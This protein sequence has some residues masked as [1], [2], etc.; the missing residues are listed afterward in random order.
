MSTQAQPTRTHRERRLSFG[1]ERFSALYL[2]AACIIT[3]GIWTPHLF[4][5][6]ATPHTI[7]SQQ[8]IPAIVAIAVLVPMAAGAF[9]LTVGA[10]TNLIAVLVVVLQTQHHFGM[11]TAIL[12]SLAAGVAI[13]ATNGFLVVVVGIDSFIVTLGMSVVLAAVQGIISGEQQPTPV[14][15][16]SWMNLTQRPVFGFQAVIVYVL[17]IALVIWWLLD[18]T[19]AGRYLYATGGNKQAAKLSGVS[20]GKWQWISLMISG[21]L[22]AVAGVLYGSLNGP[23]LTFGSGILLPAFAAVFLG[24]TQIRPGRPNIWGTVIATFLLA[25]AVQGLQL[26]TG[27]QWLNEMF[28]GL[29]LLL[30]VGFAVTRQRFVGYGVSRRRRSANRATTDAGIVSEQ[31]RSREATDRDPEHDLVDLAGVDATSREGEG[32]DAAHPVAE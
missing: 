16:N 9:D 4:L 18:H 21:G 11:W 3:F 30:A 10:S 1:I 24:S 17:V 25:T 20:V 13:G 6:S 7:A 26:V 23:S 12:L 15:S 31:P 28:S 22:C 32:Q 5:T 2:W 14:A 19:A 29:A 8:A 27:V